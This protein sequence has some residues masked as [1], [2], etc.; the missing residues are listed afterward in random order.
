MSDLLLVSVII[1]TKNEERTI[2]RLLSSLD[3]QS[4]KSFEVIVVD[5]HS[6]DRT[7]QIARNHK[8]KI[9]IFGPER[10]AQRNLGAKKAKGKYFLFVDA[11]MEFSPK[12]IKSCVE[13]IKTKKEIGAIIIPEE[14]IAKGFWE[15][16][17]AFER[18]FY[19]ESGDEVTDAARFFTREAF[20]KVGG[21]DESI[22]GPEDWDLPDQVKKQRYIIERVKEKIFHHENIP[23]PFFLA[24]KKYYYGLRAHRY[25]EK[26]NISVMSAKTIY[27]LRPA[28]YKQ[29][30]KFFL[31]PFLGIGMVIMLFC[32][33]VGGGLG[34]IIGKYKKL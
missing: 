19:N 25:L 32:E 24:H 30:R 11:D 15:K 12:V 21:Y 27:F 9:F 5:N 8:V 2:G 34:Y 7:F 4:Y 17:K 29:W 26:N 22:T 1:T 20:Q 23:S 3:Q 28:F 14:S 13:K 16:V 18:S 10:S 33:T 6:T 31:H